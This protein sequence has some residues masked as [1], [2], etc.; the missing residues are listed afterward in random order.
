MNDTYRFEL[1]DLNYVKLYSLFHS[2]GIVNDE[3]LRMKSGK[4]TIN[5][6]VTLYLP[7]VTL[8]KLKLKLL[9]ARCHYKTF[10][11]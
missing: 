6:Y 4:N 11:L 9:H 10:Y 5:S 2:F 7:Y 8:W 1:E 3:I